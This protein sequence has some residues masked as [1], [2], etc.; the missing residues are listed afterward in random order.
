MNDPVF[1]VQSDVYGR[2][3]ADPYFS[4]IAVINNEK[5][6]IVDDVE[7]AI[8]VF[9]SK[10]GKNGAA[11]V[12]DRPSRNVDKP[13]PI[14]PQFQ[15]QI[16]VVV[17]EFPII[18]RATG[19]TGK[20]IESM[21]SEVMHL[22]HGWRPSPSVGQIWCDVD[23]VSPMVDTGRMISNQILFRS[24]MR[25]AAPSRVAT[26]LISGTAESFT[27]TCNTPS[28][29]IYYTTDGSFPWA[30]NASAILY[31]ITYLIAETGQ[32]IV[33]QNGDPLVTAL[34]GVVSSGTY[35]RAAAYADGKQG[36]DVTAIT[37]T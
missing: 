10:G 19:G 35:V 6:I 21:T 1:Q 32:I 25:F 3:S 2:I 5:G 13:E 8:K 22:V 30:G 14:G 24:H 34:A 28:A 26:P 36:S 29:S 18:N 20:T 27:I 31:G 4:D 23:A 7:T 33:T 16:P 17:F 12:V 37:L 15:V 11:I 9:I